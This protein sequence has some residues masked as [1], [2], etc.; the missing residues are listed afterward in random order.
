MDNTH[1]I[2]LRTREA[3]ADLKAIGVKREYV[4][5]LLEISEL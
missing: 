5:K 1:H 3:L 4:G 2:L